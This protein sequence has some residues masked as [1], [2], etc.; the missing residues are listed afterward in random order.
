MTLRVLYLD[1]T[2]EMGG[3]EH[4]LFDLVSRLDRTRIRARLATTPGGPLVDYFKAIDIP[5]SLFTMAERARFLAREQIQR[6]PLRSALAQVPELLRV[7]AQLRRIFAQ[8]RTDLLQTNT[9]KA[10]VLGSLAVLGSRTPLVWHLQDLITQRGDN[11]TL[12]EL[13][14]RLVRPRIVCISEAVRQDLPPALQV[15]AQ[16]IPNGVDVQALHA[17]VTGLE[18]RR[19]FGIPPEAFLVGMV[20]HLIPWKGHRHLLAAAQALRG[21]HPE[22]YYLCVGGEILQFRGE[23]QRLEEQAR[24]LGVADRVTFTGAQTD[25]ADFMQAF[26]LLAL[27]S[28][29]EPFGRVLIEAMAFGKPIVATQGGGVPEIVCAGETGLLVPVADADALAKALCRFKQNP[30]FTQ[31]AGRSG[32]Q[33]VEKY[34]TLQTMAGQFTS[35]YGAL[36]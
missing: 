23:Q 25:V 4:N 34:F 33:R 17:R 32:R 35:L 13:C 27:P 18:V 12:L 22:L 31:K 9:L 2:S 15:Q 36:Q 10:H 5:V 29:H 16:V 26:D 7:Q 14:A 11:R 1:H 20:G 6:A 24:R 30:D 19:A 3:A 28:E 21:G 8:H